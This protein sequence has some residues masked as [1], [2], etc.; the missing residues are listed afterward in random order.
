MPE[1]L[2]TIDAFT[3][4][5]ESLNGFPSKRNTAVPVGSPDGKDTA[6][7]IEFPGRLLPVVNKDRAGLD[8]ES[9]PW[10]LAFTI[11]KR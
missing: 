7:D 4:D 8:N 1:E 11:M 6:P 5:P 10:L 9:P 2:G 3:A